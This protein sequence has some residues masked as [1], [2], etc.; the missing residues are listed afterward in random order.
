[1]SDLRSIIE[2]GYDSATRGDWEGKA[3][4]D[5]LP[6]DERTLADALLGVYDEIGSFDLT[7]NIWVGYQSATENEDSAM[8]VRCDKCAFWEGDGGCL[9][10]DQEVEAGGR[11]R[12]VIIPPGV[13]MP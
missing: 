7:D 6:D 9:I 11:C 4:Y 2:D 1:M 13:V 3:L 8:G 10:L 12:F 5:A